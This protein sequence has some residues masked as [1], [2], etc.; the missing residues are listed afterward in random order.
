MVFRWIRR[1]RLV[2]EIRSWEVYRVTTV[3]VKHMKAQRPKGSC[4]RS[5]EILGTCGDDKRVALVM[6]IQDMFLR[7]WRVFR[8]L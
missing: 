4:V 5:G 2:L 1:H 6:Q 7:T 3:Y 8:S